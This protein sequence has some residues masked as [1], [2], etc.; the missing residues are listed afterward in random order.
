MQQKVPTFTKI[1]FRFIAVSRRLSSTLFHTICENNFGVLA[2]P[3][4]NYRIFLVYSVLAFLWFS[5][6]CFAWTIAVFTV[7][8][9]IETGQL[10]DKKKKSQKISQTVKRCRV[11]PPAMTLNLKK[12]QITPSRDMHACLKVQCHV[13][14][15]LV[16]WRLAPFVSSGHIFCFTQFVNGK[17]YVE[18]LRKF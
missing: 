10:S 18:N 2:I 8:P 11:H 13:T 4:S 7:N 14:W 6:D 5:L 12:K 3:S 16:L 9:S 1:Y 17:G 15:K